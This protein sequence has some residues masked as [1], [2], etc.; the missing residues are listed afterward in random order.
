MKILLLITGLGMGG[1]EKVVTSLGDALATKGHDVRIA[2]L[3]GDAVVLPTHANVQVI[4][5]G[6]VTQT[7]A[8]SAFF[9]LRK[10][11]CDFQP[12]VVHSHMVHAN[13]VARL[14]RLT[15]PVKR[16]ISTAHNSN[17]GGTLRMLAYRLTNALA[18]ISTNVSAEAVAA[19][20][21]AKA[22]KPGR[23]LAVHNGIDTDAFAFSA[24]ARV[25]LR[26]ALLTHEEQ[27]GGK[28]ILAVGRL[29]EQKDYPNLLHAFAQ[30]PLS[31]AGGM[32]HQLC[33][34]GEGPLRGQLEALAV[35]LGIAD[36]VQFLGVRQD[37]AALMSAVDVFVLSSAWE[38]FGLVV[39]EA[40]ACQR[41]VVATDC[42]GVREVVDDAGYL[43][44]PKDTKALAQS[45]QTVLQLPA[46]ESA[47]LGRAARQRVIDNFSLDAAVD[48]WLQLYTGNGLLNISPSDGCNGPLSADRSAHKD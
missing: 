34:A 18:D 31:V 33:I 16:L 46:D 4:S 17:E 44:K 39:A 6:M 3:T 30:L 32:Q 22:V 28:L 48:K 26:Q 47:A 29:N 24:A 9:K 15:T 11:I 10:L 36:R 42:G 27:E 5:L 2:Y 13:L 14:V 40:M 25:R 45:I 7:N 1:A 41:V 43:V 38:G 35:Q 21:A 20:V 8:V 12:D 19:F 37:V 23:M